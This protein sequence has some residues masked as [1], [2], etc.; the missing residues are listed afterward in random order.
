MHSCLPNSFIIGCWMLD[1]G[2]WML[3]VFSP[4]TLSGEL[5]PIWHPCYNRTGERSETGQMGTTK[6]QLRVCRK[7]NPT[8]TNTRRVCSYPDD[9][10]DASESN[11][12]N[13][14]QP[15]PVRVSANPIDVR[16]LD[17]I[18]LISTNSEL[19]NLKKF[20]PPRIPS[21]TAV[22]RRLVSPKSDEGGSA[23]RADGLSSALRLTSTNFD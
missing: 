8:T 11:R 4:V 14:S 19:K 23:A 1:V 5:S 3:D 2:C 6:N 22:S 17:Q 15:V 18:R 20:P 9:L 12:S 13:L 16:R 7:L 10:L 21:L